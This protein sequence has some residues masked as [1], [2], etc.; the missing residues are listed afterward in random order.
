[1]T[2]ASDNPARKI[3]HIDMDA[4]F[5]SV[6]QRDNPALR[7][8]PVAVGGSAQ[9]G[10]VAAASYEARKFG[11]RSAM[12]SVTAARRCPELLF[13]P[14]R[15]EV[16]RA[17]S[18]QIRQIFARYS[19]LVEPLSLDEAYLDVTQDKRQIGS[20]VGIAQLIRSA[21][22][23]ETSLTASAGV[24]Y[25][26]FLAKVAS[27]QNKPD[28]IFVIRPHE[29]ADFVASLPVRRFYGVGP[30]TAERMASLGIQLGADL[31]EQS[32]DFLAL[33]FGKSAEYLYHAARGID[34]RQVKPDRIRK[35]VGR[36]QTYSEDLVAN[37]DLCEA[38]ERVIDSVWQRIEKNDVL[39][40]TVT[41]KVKYADF[42]QITRSLSLDDCLTQKAQFAAI[43]RQLLA[44]LLP[45]T[46]GVRLLGLTLSGLAAVGSQQRDEPAAQM[47]N[48]QRRFDF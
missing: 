22:R 8:K 5:A 29:G 6:E 3:I 10:V 19:D 35:S 43:G 14:P 37:A 28:G 9:R 7:G 31:R 34:H 20:A 16:Y 30:K 21:I 24:S 32:V 13:V 38:L 36:E 12:P 27:D 48:E 33:H 23:E 46:A 47:I 44:A 17:V 18:Q 41:L 42:R 39:G 4:F 26:K 15:F 25:N 40:R 11:V 45:V 2:E 1:M